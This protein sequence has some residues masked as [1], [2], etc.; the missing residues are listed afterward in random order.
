LNTAIG[1]KR[2]AQFFVM[3]ALLEGIDL[4]PADAFDPRRGLEAQQVRRRKNYFRVAVRVGRLNIALD[5][6]VVHQSVDHISRLAFGRA[7]HGG[8]PHQITHIDK[9]HDGDA[10]ILAQ[11]LE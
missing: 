11:I 5:H 4:L 1:K 10:L 2:V 7:D 8:M 9:R 3:L 6:I